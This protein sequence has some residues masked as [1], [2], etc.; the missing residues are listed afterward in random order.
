MSAP[1]V[2]T[3]TDGLLTLADDEAGL[4]TG[5]GYECQVTE[6]S[7]NATP[8]LQTVPATFCSPESQSPA[9]TGFELAV[10]WLQDWTAPGGGLSNFA[11][12]HDT[13][14]QWFS[15]SLDADNSSVV[16]VGQLRLVAG[17]YGGAAGTPLTATA[18]W[19]L[20]G[21]PDITVPSAGASASTGA[22]AGTPGTWQPSGSVPP[23]DAAGASAVTASPA[24]AWTTGQY[25][26]GSTAG[27][28]GEMHWDG[29]A[30]VA[31]QAP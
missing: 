18:T 16:C 3:I 26:Q 24:T 13:E 4:A 27:A 29:A 17:A 19:P 21:K 6:A 5:T 22:N 11:F 23:A 14:L 8:N 7:I 28:A 20:A 9:A 12:L 10:T 1:T 25:V 2:I 31:G 15:L 30:W